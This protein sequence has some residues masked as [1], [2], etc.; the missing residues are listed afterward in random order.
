MIHSSSLSRRSY[1]AP[2]AEQV[3]LCLLC[4]WLLLA[5]VLAKRSGNAFDI[6]SLLIALLRSAG[7]ESRYVYGTVQI[8]SEQV[9]NWVG[10]VKTPEVAQQIL[11]QGGIPNT[12]LASGGKVVMIRLEH[13]WVEA[14]IKYHPERGIDHVGGTSEGDSWV[15]LD[16]SF[17]QYT[18][19]ERM[20][21]QEAVPFDAEAL[22]NAAQQGAEVNEAEGWV[23]NVNQTAVENQFKA[24]QQQLK[25]Y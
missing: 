16:A 8:P 20:D 19:T 12:G 9:M 23:R 2:Y 14:W 25:T 17:K 10:G 11:G 21:L 13:V 18:Y 3:R 15:P 6:A 5:M 22:L 7:I 4:L 1:L 24:Y